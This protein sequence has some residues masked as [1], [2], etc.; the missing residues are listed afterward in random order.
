M[1]RDNKKWGTILEAASSALFDIGE[2]DARLD[3]FIHWGL[4]AAREWQI[5]MAKE[6]KTE[7]LTMTPHK[8]ILLP[9]DYVDWVKV[10]IKDGDTIKTFIHDNT[11][12][13]T[14]DCVNG[15]KKENAPYSNV[16]LWDL[17]V[18][19]T[20]Y[21][22]HNVHGNGSDY[23]VYGYGYKDNGLGY[24]KVHRETGE[25]QFRGVV[26][27]NSKIALEYIS[28]GWDPNKETVVNPLAFMLIKRYIHWM[29]KLHNQNIPRSHV[30]EA[31]R[32]YWNEFDKVSYRMLDL[33]IED[34]QDVARQAFVATV[35]I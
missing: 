2:T 22:F 35:Q 12:A 24:F 34:V 28:D 25:I 11:M 21:L 18:D 9:D 31:E 13:T 27:K 17:D 10:G 4:E 33:T 23:P 5:D 29:N 1:A 15:V 19:T 30:E 32:L 14:H 26:P 16:N 20:P 6:I 3:Q 8:S 7:I